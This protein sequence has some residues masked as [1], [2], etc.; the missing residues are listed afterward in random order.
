[1]AVYGGVGEH[2]A[3]GV[4]QQQ[5]AAA[6]F[7]RARVLGE[8]SVGSE[9]SDVADA[10]AGG[11][12]A[13]AMSSYLGDRAAYLNASVEQH[14]VVVANGSETLLTVPTVDVG[15]GERFALASGGAMD[16]DFV[17]LSHNRMLIVEC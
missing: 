8:S 6:L 4:E 5:Q 7:R 9:A 3:Q 1:M 13:A 14:D 10:D 15:G 2:L 17:N 16:Y 12:V 11:V